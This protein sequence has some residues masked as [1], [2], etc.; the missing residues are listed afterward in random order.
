M[1][2]IRPAAVAHQFY[3]GDAR[4]LQKTIRD[5]LADA[6]G[7]SHHPKALIVPHAGYVYS[8]A[9][10]ASA[11]RGIQPFAHLIRRVVL[12]GPSHRV[13]FRGI[14]LSSADFFAS[15]LGQVP[16]DHDVIPGLLALPGVQ[17][18]DAAHSQ[19][20][21]L[22][23]QLPFLQEI[24][25]Q[26]SLVPLVAGDCAAETVAAVLEYLWG[27]D[28][29]LIIVS[30]DLSHYHDYET[31]RQMDQHTSL[32]PWHRKK[33]MLTMPAGGYR[34]MACYWRHAIIICRRAPWICETPGIPPAP[35][36][37]WWAMVRLCWNPDA[38][39]GSPAT[40]AAH[41]QP[42]HFTGL[43]IAFGTIAFPTPQRPLGGT[44]SELCKP[45]FKWPVTR[46]HR[47]AGSPSKPGA[48]RGRQCLPGRVS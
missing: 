9:V 7:E 5:F 17:L 8:G 37:R 22:E 21:S 6:V 45:A 30:S 29:T 35:E 41:C 47:Y 2:M 12:L 19:E 42:C 34:S 24:I 14:A 27:G 16:V 36:I 10:A 18:L 48:G 32:N 40:I 15:P 20:H 46:L 4:N 25:P 43:G 23:V 26:F 38:K 31:A 44:G 28:E 13:P 11:Y 3:P 33:S 1:M 39:P